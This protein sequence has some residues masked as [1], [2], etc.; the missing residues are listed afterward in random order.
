MRTGKKNGHPR[1][2]AAE[3]G[4]NLET[5][6][7]APGDRPGLLH[8]LRRAG[9]DPERSERSSRAPRTFWI[10]DPGSGEWRLL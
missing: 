1:D 9:P 7:L 4:F 3:I 6:A 5:H 2:Y 8:W 10:F